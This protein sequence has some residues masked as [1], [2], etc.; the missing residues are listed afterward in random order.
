VILGNIGGDP[1]PLPS[2]G[3][4]GIGVAIG[5]GS[6]VSAA[7]VRAAFAATMACSA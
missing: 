3:G 5:G 2:I 7:S 6:Q 4:I 1:E